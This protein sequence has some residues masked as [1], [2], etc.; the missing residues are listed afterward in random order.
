LSRIDAVFYILAAT[1]S[2]VKR[3]TFGVTYTESTAQPTHRAVVRSDR[4]TR[5]ELL[6]WGPAGSATGLLWFD[7][8]TDAVATLLDGV[9]GIVDSRL[10]A[11]DGG[12]YAFV[13]REE[14]EFDA[15]TL[16]LVDTAG[17]AFVPPLVFLETGRLRFEAVGPSERLGAF[18]RTL[19][20][21]FDAEIERVS[22]F[23]RR[24]EPAAVTDRQREALSAALAAG[25]YEIPRTGSVADVAAALDCATG[26]AG[27]L[28][29][30]AE[31]SVVRAFLSA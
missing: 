11:G 18:H 9:D 28:L 26:T 4:I 12:T 22:G 29:R 6:T 15:A 3:A 21:A 2:S 20:E 23:R 7:G 24:T 19:S 31:S 25:Y 17:V 27:E 16:D 14:Y 10:A 1:T 8:P 30:K 5:G 13:D